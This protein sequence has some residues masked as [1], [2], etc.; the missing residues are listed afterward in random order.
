MSPAPYDDPELRALL[1]DS[2]SDVQPRNG[3]DRIRAR[4]R[5]PVRRLL[6]AT[7]AAACATVLV[8]GGTAWLARPG[9][10][11]SA[12]SG[13]GD[14]RPSAGATTARRTA[15]VLVYYV[16]RTAV[17]PRLFS[18][19]H[20]VTGVTAPDAQVAVREALAGA[21]LDPDYA[22]TLG[23]LG[24]SVVATTNDRA[25]TL[26]FDGPPARPATMDAESA[27]LALQALVWT[28]DAAVGAAGPVRF[29]VAGNPAR[30]VLGVDTE[31]PVQRASADSVLSSVS[32]ASP[33]EG[34]TV[35]TR[36]EVSGSAAT[37]EANVVWELK[38]GA[39]VVGH[40]FTTAAQCC[41][42]APY[43]L[44]VTAAP[45]DYTLVVHDID[46][47]DGEGVGTSQDTKNISVR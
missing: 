3:T 8:I 23:N 39:T 10:D 31:S 19:T 13:P 1:S 45:G 37:F 7:V 2:V 16:G 27:R 21:P 22:N 42:L 25:V 46:E 15:E 12:T 40:G 35:P 14:D 44:T 26:D 18:E 41:T 34:D 38:R 9:S 4:Y 30:Q 33:G 17:G 29:T 6:P 11:R 20:K 32:I 28:A 24:V 5:R 43:S 47:S 36:F